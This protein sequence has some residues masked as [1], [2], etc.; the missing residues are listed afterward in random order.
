[1]NLPSDNDEQIQLVCLSQTTLNFKIRQHVQQ[2]NNDLTSSQRRP[3]LTGPAHHVD[4]LR[5]LLARLVP[6][7][8]VLPALRLHGLVKTIPL[9]FK[10]TCSKPRKALSSSPPGT[11]PSRRARTCLWSL[12][13][14]E[15]GGLGEQER[16]Q[17][18]GA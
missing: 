17:G 11:P 8:L 5:N 15:G 10:L 4:G 9:D 7:L 18:A 2:A 1:M 3:D 14:E 13:T 6:H 12:C 16:R